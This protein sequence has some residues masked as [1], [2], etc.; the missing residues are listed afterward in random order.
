M[1]RTALIVED[2]PIVTESLK[3]IIFDS[4]IGLSCIHASTGKKGLATLNGNRVDIVLLDINLPDIN[5][6][7]FCSEA[8]SRFPNIKILALTSLSQRFVVEQMLSC[9]ANGFVFKTSDTSEIIRAIQEVLAGNHFLGSGVKE[10]VN[11]KNQVQSDL[12]ALTRRENEI[13]VHIADGLTNQE[14]ADKLFISCSTVDSHRKNLLLK[15][16]VNN[17]AKL[18]R[19]ALKH[20][21]IS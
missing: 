21:I 15:F 7:Q 17:T 19:I 5:G 18:I 3:K 12:P 11:G 4:E 9:G 6:M 8:R 1:V 13:L 2:H 10:L 16:N 14:I 20:G